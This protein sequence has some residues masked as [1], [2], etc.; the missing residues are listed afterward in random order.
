MSF[1]GDCKNNRMK[2]GFYRMNPVKAHFFM[3]RERKKCEK[4]AEIP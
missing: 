4:N 3:E 2:M 1:R